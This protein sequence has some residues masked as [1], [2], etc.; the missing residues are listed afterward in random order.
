MRFRVAVERKPF[1]DI[2]ES[3]RKIEG[4]KA[5]AGILWAELDWTIWCGKAEEALQEGVDVDGLV[6]LAAPD[7]R[8]LEAQFNVLGWSKAHLL[9]MHPG[10][11]RKRV[12]LERAGHELVAEGAGNSGK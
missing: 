5:G 7:Y 12:P 2:G 9:H 10:I 3:V 8:A 11:K 1:P 4:P 6:I